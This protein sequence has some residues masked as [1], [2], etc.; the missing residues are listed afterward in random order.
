[1]FYSLPRHVF[2]Q[3]QAKLFPRYFQFSVLCISV[4]L[5]L[6]VCA[7]KF[8]GSSKCMP[9]EQQ[10][11]LIAVW[12]ILLLNLL[13]FEPVTTKVM[14]LRHA[15]ER[16]LGTGHEV[17]QL[18]PWDP[19][20]AKDPELVSLSARFGKLHGCSTSLNLLGLGL[21]CWHICWI[22]ARL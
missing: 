3:L 4:C 7:A 8:R 6:E 21:G 19:V 14:F 15:V 13:Y 17:G 11:N 12:G 1:M 9:R 10:M 5:A 2:G 16:R 22:G 18:R 20:K